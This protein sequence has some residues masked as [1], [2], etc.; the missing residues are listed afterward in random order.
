[1]PLYAGTFEVSY[2]LIGIM[3]AAE[4]IEFVT[5]AHVGVNVDIDRVRRDHDA[6]LLCCGALEGIDIDYP[7]RPLRG[8]HM[9]MPYL[10]MAIRRGLGDV[11]PDESFVDAKDRNVVVIG[12][13]DTGTDCIGTAIRQ[14]CR[15]LVNFARKPMPPEQRDPEN[16]WPQQPHVYIVDYGHEEGRA[17]F[18][19]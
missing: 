1:M 12:A 8:I 7:G 3:L 19:P 16:P 15:S 9:A 6:V 14:G 17:V 10:T 2:G 11:I 5:D 13:G 18:G 4:G